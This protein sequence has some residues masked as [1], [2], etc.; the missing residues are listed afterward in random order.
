MEPE[1]E[2]VVKEEVEE[3]EAVEMEEK[4]EEDKTEY[5]WLFLLLFLGSLQL[6]SMEKC[7]SSAN[8]GDNLQE[9]N[10]TVY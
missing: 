5:D 7:C 4:E 1:E 6:S 8:K 3:E 10:E 9:E 2:M